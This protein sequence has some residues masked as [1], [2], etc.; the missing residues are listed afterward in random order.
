MELRLRKP[1]NFTPSCVSSDPNSSDS[2]KE[3]RMQQQQPVAMAEETEKAFLK[4]P[5]VFLSL[6]QSGEGKRP[7]K[8]G[9]R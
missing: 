7:G 2:I 8:A 5:K 9:N 3:R 6:K 1:L 4:Q